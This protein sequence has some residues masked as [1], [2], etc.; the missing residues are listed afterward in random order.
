MEWRVDNSPGRSF[1][2]LYYRHSPPAAEYIRHHPLAKS[3]IRCFLTPVV[4]GI[5]YPWI[6][7]PVMGGF[8]F[9][10]FL[11][12]KRTVKKPVK[13]DIHLDIRKII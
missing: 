5:I 10:L 9:V 2:A 11:F 1:V 4:Y 3:V 13:M 8:F 6:S 7:V 12:I